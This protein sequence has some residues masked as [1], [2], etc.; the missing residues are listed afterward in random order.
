MGGREKG[1][2]VASKR[3]KEKLGE[4]KGKREN[5]GKVIC[6]PIPLG[7]QTART[8]P[9]TRRNDFLVEHPLTSDCKK[10]KVG[11]WVQNL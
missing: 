5:T 3:E 4:E 9:R 8:H 11:T 10:I 1:K 2:F 7:N 6:D